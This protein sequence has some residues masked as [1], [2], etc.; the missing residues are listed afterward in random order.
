M[1]L[2]RGRFIVWRTFASGGGFWNGSNAKLKYVHVAR[3]AFMK[4]SDTVLALATLALFNCFIIRARSRLGD[5]QMSRESIFD[6]V[7]WLNL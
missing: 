2:I 6:V 7:T 1:T 3:R 4:F 5:V